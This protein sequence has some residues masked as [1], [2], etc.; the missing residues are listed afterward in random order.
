MLLN[1][2][3]SARKKR[4]NNNQ[5]DEAEKNRQAK[6]N[7]AILQLALVVGSFAIGYVPHAGKF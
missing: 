3:F 7:H 6:E 1:C 5:Q 4:P 2:N